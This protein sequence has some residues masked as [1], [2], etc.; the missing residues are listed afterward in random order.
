MPVGWGKGNTAAA[1]VIGAVAEA[2]ERYAG[3]MPDR[4]RITW[5][6]P[7]ELPGAVLDPREFALYDDAQLAR[8]GFP[9]VRFDRQA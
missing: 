8:P 5:A 4:T 6:R 2:I 7:A 1:A 3:S 9:F